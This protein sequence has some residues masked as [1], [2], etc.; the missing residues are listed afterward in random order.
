M[1][2]YPS[3]YLVMEALRD[4]NGDRFPIQKG[5]LRSIRFGNEKPDFVPRIVAQARAGETLD[6]GGASVYTDAY[7]VVYD[8]PGPLPDTIKARMP[9]SVS[10]AAN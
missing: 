3:N 6:W 9:R 10:A 4:I 5:E 1:Q 7:R 2:P 8:G